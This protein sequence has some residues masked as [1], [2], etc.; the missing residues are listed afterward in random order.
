MSAL[1]MILTAAL[2]VSGSGPEKVSGE[3]EV[4]RA[5]DL[6]SRWE[7]VCYHPNGQYEAGLI[8]GQLADLRGGL[9][10]FFSEKVVD[11]G[12]GHLR[13]NVAGRNCLGIYRQDESTLMIR[14]R[15]ACH[16]YP[17][18]F[19]VGNVFILRRVNPAK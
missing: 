16:G 15:D 14:Y 8:G 18:S 9:P 4:E 10:A 13:I 11:Q 7:G 1:A 5:L 19:A 3:I 2:A 12:R 17:T 6:A